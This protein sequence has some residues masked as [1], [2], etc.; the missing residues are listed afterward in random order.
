MLFTLAQLKETMAI[1]VVS[2]F[3]GSVANRKRRTV[4]EGPHWGSARGVVLTVRARQGQDADTQG[5][6]RRAVKRGQAGMHSRVSE[7]WHVPL[8]KSNHEGLH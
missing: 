6:M 4:D 2:L 8:L 1:G 7:C 3:V 5:L